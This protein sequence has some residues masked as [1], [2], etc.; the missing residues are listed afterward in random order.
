ML[1]EVYENL[2]VQPSDHNT[3]TLGSIGAHNIVIACLPSGEYG[4]ASAATVA[5]HMLSS[6]QSVK[7][8]LL[9]GTGGGIPSH[10]EDI[11]LGDVVVGVPTSS[12]T[13]GGVIQYDLGKAGHG[14]KFKRTGMLNR[15]PQKLLTAVSKL[16]AIH[17]ME[18]SRITSI[19]KEAAKRSLALR[20]TL[21]APQREDLLFETSYTHNQKEPTCRD[22]NPE[23]IIRRS[24]RVPD[25]PMVHYGLIASGNRVVKDSHFRNRLRRDLGACCV[26]MEAAG[27]MNNFPCLVV[28]GICDYADSHKNKD[29]QGYAAAVAAAYATELLLITPMT[30]ET[31]QKDNYLRLE[32]A[33]QE[34]LNSMPAVE[35]EALKKRK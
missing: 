20:T 13:H 23:R 4:I 31:A 28:R 3:Y 27:L 1:D 16:Q 6:F 34:R 17:E 7:I 26:D 25:Q 35:S 11:R 12:N 9:V 19:M 14:D 10:D 29:W 22:C 18:G 15:P 24:P 33:A 5:M 32:S 2:P 21:E 30:I 8:G